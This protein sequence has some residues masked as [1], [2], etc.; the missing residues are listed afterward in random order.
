MTHLQSFLQHFIALQNNIQKQVGHFI[1]WGTLSLVLITALVVILRY[2]FDSGSIALQESIM[3]NHATVFMLGVSYTYLKD[4]HVRVDLFY[5]R[6]S[7][8]KKAWIDMIG[9]LLFT[10]PI[11]I[12]II[13]TSYDYILASWSIQESSAEAGGLGY[14]FLLKTL[15]AVMALLLMLQALAITA[16]S[17]QIINNWTFTH[18]TPPVNGG[19]L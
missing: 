5:S 8:Y 6:F 10:L 4:E 17:I 1:A 9:S 2:G 15:I 13:W 18:P 19:K 12:F 14:L 11:T 7:T 16:R 3:Y